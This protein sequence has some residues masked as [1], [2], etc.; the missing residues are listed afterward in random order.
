MKRILRHPLSLP[1]SILWIYL[2]AALASPASAAPWDGC[3]TIPK[4]PK[5]SPGEYIG[6]ATGRPEDLMS[7]VANDTPENVRAWYAQRL[8][9][10][11]FVDS[12]GS[13]PPSWQFREPNSRRMVIIAF[14][15]P[16]IIRFHCP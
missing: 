7:Q 5:G 14:G 4:Y 11:T 1:G 12:S 3:R 6:R 2:A 8:P 9:T 13:H 15:S 10:W 16:L